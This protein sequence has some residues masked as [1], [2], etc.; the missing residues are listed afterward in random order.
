MLTMTQPM[1]KLYVT[2]FADAQVALNANNSVKRLSIA[3][4][5][6]GILLKFC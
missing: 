5:F 6:D 2:V 3:L 1:S 4:F